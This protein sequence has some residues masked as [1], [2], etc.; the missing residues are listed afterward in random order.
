[1]NKKGG[2]VQVNALLVTAYRW[3]FAITV[4]FHWTFP[5]FTIGPSMFLALRWQSS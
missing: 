4:N 2:Q 5:A 3:Q 1:M